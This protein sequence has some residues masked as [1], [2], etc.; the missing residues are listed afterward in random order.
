M[1]D[2]TDEQVVDWLI[3]AA[4]DVMHPQGSGLDWAAID[5]YK[6]EIIR[7]LGGKANGKDSAGRF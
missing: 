5:K 4:Q 1:T 2:Y 3:E 7:R 6:R